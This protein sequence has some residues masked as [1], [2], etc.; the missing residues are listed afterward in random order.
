MQS[1]WDDN[2]WNTYAGL[3][4]IGV[5][6]VKISSTIK[7]DIFKMQLIEEMFWNINGFST[8]K[9]IIYMPNDL[10][11]KFYAKLKT[12]DDL[13]IIYPYCNRRIKLVLHSPNC[14]I[15]LHAIVMPLKKLITI[16]RR[17]KIIK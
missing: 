3:F 17:C 8:F 12:M 16:L 14:M 15:L 2:R 10:R 7:D 11:K 13:T 6:I 5:E 1:F 9:Q 4:K